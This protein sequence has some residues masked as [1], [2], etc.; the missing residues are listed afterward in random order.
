MKNPKRPKTRARSP[1]PS[2]SP[3]S[4]PC[5]EKDDDGND[6]S[7]WAQSSS[8]S[9]SNQDDQDEYF[10]PEAYAE[11][12][13][14]QKPGSSLC[15]ENACEADRDGAVN[16]PDISEELTEILSHSHSEECNTDLVTLSPLHPKTTS[17]SGV[18]KCQECSRVFLNKESLTKHEYTVHDVCPISMKCT[19]CGHLAKTSVELRQHSIQFHGD[20]K[21][22]KCLHKGCC[23]SGIKRHDVV[24]HMMVHSNL[25]LF[26]CQNCGRSFKSEYLCRQHFNSCYNLKKFICEVCGKRFNQ[27]P[28]M[29]QHVAT[30]HEGAKP[31]LCTFCG[32]TFSSGGNLK[33]HLRIHKNSFP[34]PC[35]FCKAKFRHSNTLK[36]HVETKHKIRNFKPQ[37]VL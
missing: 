14:S 13:S 32:K 31:Y 7:S 30:M 2:L 22:F 9:E 27:E 21:P 25:K 6:A 1:T 19:Y 24:V 16:N 28:S 35:K 37:R 5:T 33:R 3:P 4:S 10:N 18:F 20:S 15:V 34:Y 23:F 36:G 29:R 8:D 12:G 11:D 17:T 26:R